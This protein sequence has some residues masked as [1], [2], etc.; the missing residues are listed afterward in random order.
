[1]DSASLPNADGDFF[2]AWVLNGTT[3][4]VDI[5]KAIAYQQTLLNNIAK[6]EAQHRT[7]N[8]GAGIDNVLSDADWLALLSTARAA[9]GTASTTQALRDALKPLQEAIEANK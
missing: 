1:M 6:Q 3:V 8:V 4:T 7:T 2:N 9:V 5:T